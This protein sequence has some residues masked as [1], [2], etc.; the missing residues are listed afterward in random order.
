MTTNERVEYK[1]AVDVSA[2]LN[3]GFHIMGWDKN[4]GKYVKAISPGS[5]SE[6]GNGT[7]KK[8][9]IDE[10]NLVFGT[11]TA[12]VAGVATE[13]TFDHST[14]EAE[15]ASAPANDAAIVFEYKK[16]N[17]EPGAILVQDVVQDQEEAALMVF[18]GVVYSDQLN[19]TEFVNIDVVARL[20]KQGIY[21]E[22]RTEFLQTV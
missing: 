18:A 5:Q 11:L 1:D 16:F 7:T 9:T 22:P 3:N 21:L 2:A 14:G 19:E 17:T 12:K 15:F 4:A 6:T 8:F 10:T 20:R 13:I